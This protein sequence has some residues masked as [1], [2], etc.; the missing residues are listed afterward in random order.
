MMSYNHKLAVIVN[1]ISECNV[2]ELA[3][4]I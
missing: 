3:N 1:P 2:S 4:Y